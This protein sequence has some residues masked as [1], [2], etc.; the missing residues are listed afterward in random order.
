M[1]G[2]IFDFNGT[3]VFDEKFHTIAW[4]EFLEKRIGRKV[5]QEEMDKY[6]HGVN[7]IDTL[8]YFLKRDIEKEELK[9]LTLEKEAIYKDLC[10]KSNEYHLVDGLEEFLNYLKEK[11]FL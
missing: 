9:R 3:M 8:R 5:T 1:T 11:K 6:V 7:V 4:E 10:L 2:I